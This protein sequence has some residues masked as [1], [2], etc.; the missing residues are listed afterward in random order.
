MSHWA[1]V[2][3]HFG[4]RAIFFSVSFLGFLIKASILSFAQEWNNLPLLSQKHNWLPVGSPA[5]LVEND[6]TC[7]GYWGCVVDFASNP[8][9]VDSS[10]PSLEV[11]A[12]QVVQIIDVILARSPLS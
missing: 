3:S 12:S 2:H 7:F 6:S 11:N 9:S 5:R 1:H 8:P 10:T 4:T